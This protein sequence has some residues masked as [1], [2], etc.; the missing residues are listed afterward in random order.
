[1]EKRITK[2]IS[3]GNAIS[4]KCCN[5]YF[6]AYV[7]FY[8]EDRTAYRKAKF[9]IWLDSEDVMEWLDSDEYTMQD[10]RDEAMELAVNT[11]D[12]I[13]SYDDCQ[14]FYDYCNET[15]RRFQ[16]EPQHYPY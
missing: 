15:I 9:V 3:L 1:M 16:G 2:L 12:M 14:D 11:L 13:K 10:V 5:Y 7:R 8:N 6:L 4:E